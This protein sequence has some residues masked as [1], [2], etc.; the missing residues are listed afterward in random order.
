LSAIIG[1][2]LG[3]ATE[4]AR[5]AYNDYQ[6]RHITEEFESKGMSPPLMVDLLH[7]WAL[8]VW[9]AMIFMIGGFLIYGLW[10]KHLKRKNI[11]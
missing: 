1:A 6:T 5:R 2:L 10:Y 7:W 8:P 4:L 9:T 3:G 11:G